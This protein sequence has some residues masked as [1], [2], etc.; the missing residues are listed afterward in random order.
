VRDTGEV[1]FHEGLV[2]RRAARAAE[3]G[4]A[5]EATKPVRAEVTSTQQ[6]YIDLHR[7]AAVRAMLADAPGVALRLMVAHAIAGSP[8]WRV[9]VEPQATRN[10]AV[11]ESV[12]TCLG[13]TAFDGHRRAALDRLG[14]DA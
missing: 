10:D 7:H 8:H 1:V 3:R 12:E 2:N 9:Q 4:E 6:T 14:M 5:P 11:R 13:E